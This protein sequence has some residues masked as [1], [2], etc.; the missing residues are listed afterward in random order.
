VDSLLNR[1]DYMLLADYEAYMDRQDQA[2]EAYRDP[3]RWARM[4]ILNTARCGYFSSD[5]SMNDYAKGIW[6][7][8]PVD[9]PAWRQGRGAGPQEDGRRAAAAAAGLAGFDLTEAEWQLLSTAPATIAG[10]MTALVETGLIGT[11]SEEGTSALGL[12]QAAQAA[13]RYPGN[14]LIQAVLGRMR[15]ARSPASRVKLHQASSARPAT[16][17]SEPGSVFGTRPAGLEDAIRVCWQTSELLARKAPEAQAAEFKGWLL[18][19]A[20]TVTNAGVQAHGPSVEGAPESDLE[21]TALRALSDALGLGAS[22][23][24][25]V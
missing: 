6:Q 9:V 13:R 15:A 10:V 11:L 17:D 12:A 25:S 23:Q 18:A 24:G 22:I 21:A 16:R 7:V 14:L 2:E 19:I 20:E 3:E 5:R 8:R 4:S 1:D